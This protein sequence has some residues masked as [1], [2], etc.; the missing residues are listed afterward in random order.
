MTTETDVDLEEIECGYDP[1]DSGSTPPD[2]DG[3]LI[4]DYLDPSPLE[5]VEG[6]GNRGLH[7]GRPVIDTI[8]GVATKSGSKR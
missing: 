3:D 2:S 8:A 4:C 6:D 7:L 5:G 1:N